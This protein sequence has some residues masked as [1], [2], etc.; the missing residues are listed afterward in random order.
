M[1]KASAKAKLSETPRAYNI[2]TSEDAKR[3]AK[4]RL[5]SGLARVARQQLMCASD[6]LLALSG[7]VLGTY[8]LDKERL[9]SLRI[10]A[11]YY[12]LCGAGRR[13]PPDE[14]SKPESFEV[15]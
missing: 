12:G 7:H 1:G 8:R 3:V 13:P 10:L 9:V 5:P 11:E 15:K 6:V 14:P 2:A 4:A